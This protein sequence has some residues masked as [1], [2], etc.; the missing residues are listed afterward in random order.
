MINNDFNPYD[1]IMQAHEKIQRLETDIR[2][3]AKA[4]NGLRAVVKEHG[5]TL[6]LVIRGLEAANTANELLIKDQLDNLTK[7][8]KEELNHG[9][10][11]DNQK[12]S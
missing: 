9:E 2:E 5:M 6:D 10:T 8:L 7:Q 4:H 12:N 11:S 3:I 1:A